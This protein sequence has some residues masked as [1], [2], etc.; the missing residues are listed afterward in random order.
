MTKTYGYVRVSSI[1][2]NEERQ[3]IAMQKQ[4]IPEDCIF[5]DKMSGKNFDRPQYKAMIDILKEDD[6]LYIL[7]IDRLGRNYEEIQNQWRVLTKE[8]RIDICVLDMPILDTR[9]GKDLMGTFVADL[10]LQ[11]LS[12]GAQNERENIRKR[13]EQGIAAARQ[14][15]VHLGRPVIAAPD[16]FGEMVKKWEKKQLSLEQILK[17]C[18]M[19]EATFYRRLRE[20]RLLI[21]KK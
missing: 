19:S 9:Q 8:K 16:N 17:D 1:D 12:F 14:R 20:L 18:K 2:Q 4:Q 6:L 5:I 11:V 7:S 3:I 15:G 21:D 13:Q 10:V